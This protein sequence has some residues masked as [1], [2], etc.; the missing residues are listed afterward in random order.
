MKGFIIKVLIIAV[1]VACFGS[2]VWQAINYYEDQIIQKVIELIES[3]EFVDDIK[4]M[5]YDAVKD[6]ASDLLEQ[7]LKQFAENEMINSITP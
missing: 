7:E 2:G 3:S 1:L 5:V 4:V 6:I